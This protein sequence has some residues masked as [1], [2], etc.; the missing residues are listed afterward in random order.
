MLFKN[1]TV[2]Y[3]LLLQ[4]MVFFEKAVVFSF[5]TGF[6]LKYQQTVIIL[7]FVMKNGFLYFFQNC[8]FFLL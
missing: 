6:L 2:I 3:D 1:M 5:G 7:Y 4:L 8:R